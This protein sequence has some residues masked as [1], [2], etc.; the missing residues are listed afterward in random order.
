MRIAF[1]SSNKNK[2]HEIKSVAEEFS[3]EILSLREI[4]ALLQIPPLPEIEET[5][6]TYKENA[7]IK[8][9][10]CLEWCGLPSLGD[11]SGLEVKALGGAPGIY[12]ARYAGKGATDE[13]KIRKIL[14]ELKT[15]EQESGVIDRSAQFRAMLC[16][17]KNPHTAPVYFEGILEGEILDSPRGQNGFGYDPIVHITELEGTL[18]EF[19]SEIVCTQGFR[20]KAAKKLFS[21]LKNDT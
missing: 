6:T 4:A 13:D 1:A 8:A 17:V 9:K 15:I 7:L 16:F 12:S 14:K 20:A 10:K 19:E 3:I 2:C 21:F 18:A 5:G 11:D